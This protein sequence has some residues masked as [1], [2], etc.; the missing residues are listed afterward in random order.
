[1]RAPADCD[2]L[3]ESDP[4]DLRRGRRPLLASV[5]GLGYIRHL[6][7]GSGAHD[8]RL[9]GLRVLARGSGGGVGGRR[10]AWRARWLWHGLAEVR[11]VV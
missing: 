9:G 8:R 3:P 6:L 1:M 4:V 10:A 5:F 2:G 7:G 11:K